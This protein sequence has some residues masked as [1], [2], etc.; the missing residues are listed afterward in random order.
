MSK[1]KIDKGI[2]IPK[3]KEGQSRRVPSKYPWD[4][5]EVGDSFVWPRPYS[6]KQASIAKSISNSYCKRNP[7][8]FGKEFTTGKCGNKLRL[9]RIK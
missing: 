1:I 9:W 8:G 6:K 5:M 4:D 7:N 2:P 3:N